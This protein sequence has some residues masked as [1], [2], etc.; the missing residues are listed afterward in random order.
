MSHILTMHTCVPVMWSLWMH[1]HVCRACACKSQM[2]S[3]YRVEHL[4]TVK[5]I[6]FDTWLSRPLSVST[7][8]LLLRASIDV[9]SHSKYKRMHL[10]TV[11]YNSVGKLCACKFTIRFL[12]S[13]IPTLQIDSTPHSPHTAIRRG[14]QWCHLYHC[15]SLPQLPF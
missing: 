10:T 5:R 13:Y 15:D 9:Y 1:V 12:L 2:V 6:L 7:R 14:W 11:Y 8:T 4:S 3:A